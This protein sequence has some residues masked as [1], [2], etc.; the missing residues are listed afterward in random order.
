[1]RIDMPVENEG[2][3]VHI[4][5]MRLLTCLQWDLRPI[6]RESKQ[7]SKQGDCREHTCEVITGYLMHDFSLTA[8]RAREAGGAME[9]NASGSDRG[10]PFT[11]SGY[12]L[13]SEDEPSTFIPDPN[14]PSEGPEMETAHRSLIFWRDGFTIENGPLLRYDNPEHA[15]TLAAINAG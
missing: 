11:G 13:G 1:M 5:D 7:Q 8:T 3:F 9:E 12:T 10:K 4:S 2:V 14:A 15:A 6:S